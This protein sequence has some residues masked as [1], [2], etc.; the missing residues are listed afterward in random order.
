ME[1]GHRGMRL[2]RPADWLLA[3]VGLLVL[4]LRGFLDE[5]G[6]MKAL[7]QGMEEVEP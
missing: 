1:E 5:C 2:V 6:L 7:T 3:F 4:V